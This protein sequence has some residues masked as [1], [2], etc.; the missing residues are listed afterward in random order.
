[1][2]TQGS[3]NSQLISVMWLKKMLK[4]KDQITTFW[5]I[6][7]ISK[8]FRWMQESLNYNVEGLISFT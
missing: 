4:K 3:S 7:S 2:A 8:V 6:Q 5:F 1:M